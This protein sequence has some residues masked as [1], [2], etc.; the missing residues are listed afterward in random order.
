[1]DL[2]WTDA[3]NAW[4]LIESLKQEK[5]R[6]LD[7][8]KQHV[9]TIHD[10]NVT[11]AELKLLV[12]NPERIWLDGKEITIHELLDRFHTQRDTIKALQADSRNTLREVRVRR[13]FYRMTLITFLHAVESAAKAARAA[14][15]GDQS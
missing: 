12:N 15:F 5:R 13:D 3:F 4:K 8:N 14:L 1:M 6:L 7:L 9:E 10:R 2:N 11:I